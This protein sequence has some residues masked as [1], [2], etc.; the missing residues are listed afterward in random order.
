MR[1][2]LGMDTA[3]AFAGVAL[4]AG[5]DVA[6]ELE[7]PPGPNGRPQHATELLGA[8]ERVVAAAGGWERIDLLA[9]G[10]GPGS[11]TGLRIG[12]ATARALAHARGLPLAGVGS[13]ASLA[14]GIE[15]G[16]KARLA[17]LDARRGEVFAALYGS[18]GE[19]LWAPFVAPPEALADRAAALGGAAVAAGD[20]ALRFRDQ[21][22]AAGVVV[23]NDGSPVHRLRARHLCRLALAAAAG[24]PEAIEPVYLR[25]PDA[26]LWRERDRG[27]DPG[28][29]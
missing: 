17:V 13:L 24:R 3:T 22:E 6:A 1:T 26:E 21:L 18:A 9:V 23:P 20:G 12:V 2:V 11:F 29:R 7:V 28:D 4:R 8:V 10:V 16:S 5:D 14:A 19:E 15:A 25:R 27:R